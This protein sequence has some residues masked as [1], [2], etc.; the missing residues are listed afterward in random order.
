MKMRKTVFTIDVSEKYYEG[1]T[2]N[3]L[4]NGW[5]CPWFTKE[6]A[7]KMIDDLNKEGVKS[8]YDTETDTYIVNF[9]DLDTIDEFEGYDVETVDGVQH[10]YP[11]GA[12]CWIWDEATWMASETKN[13]WEKLFDEFLELTEF[14]LVKYDF[15]N[16]DG[17]WGLVDH[18]GGNLGNIESDRFNSAM[19]ILDRMEIYIEDY[20][21]RD[22]DELL[23]E[24]NIE[25]DWDF[26]CEAYLENARDLLPNATWDF[27]VLDMICN[28]FNEI[29]LNNCFYEKEN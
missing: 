3:R 2:D 6:V 12:W 24:K 29:D 8:K 13:K 16:G 19:Q 20:F 5:E 1:Y 4:W 18:Q 14:G 21:L 15:D 10:L 27:E 22:I 26:T 25:I 7:D 28:H 11:I 23:D 9:E 17:M